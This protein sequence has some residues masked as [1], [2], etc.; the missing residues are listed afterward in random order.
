M[1]WPPRPTRWRSAS[2]PWRSTSATSAVSL[3]ASHDHPLPLLGRVAFRGPSLSSAWEI[4][5]LRPAVLLHLK[6]HSDRF[7]ARVARFVAER[8]PRRLIIQTSSLA[9]LAS[10]QRRIPEAERLLLVFNAAQLTV[11]RRDARLGDIVDGLSVRESL[12]SPQV[13]EWVRDRGLRLYAWT[14]NDTPRFQELI[15]CGV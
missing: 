13:Q 12:V 10:V 2:A 3:A 8:P 4:A 1:T 14:V 11:L 9:T 5:S 15:R 7:V 6:D